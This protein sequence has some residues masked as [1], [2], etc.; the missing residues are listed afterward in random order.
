[1]KIALILFY[2]IWADSS[3]ISCKALGTLG[4]YATQ[5]ECEKARQEALKKYPAAHCVPCD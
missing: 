5:A 3:A 4:V 2:L 1:M